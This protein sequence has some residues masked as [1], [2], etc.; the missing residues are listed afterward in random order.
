MIT[1]MP[2]RTAVPESTV[3]TLAVS[4]SASPAPVPA[5]RSDRM[6]AVAVM[7]RAF[8]AKDPA[9]DGLFIVAVK[10]T[11]IFCRPV[12]RAKTPRPENVEFYP[13][14]DAAE[15]QGYR[16]CKLCRPADATAATAPPP[17]VARLVR[18]AG[19]RFPDRVTSADLTAEGVDPATAR[20]QFRRHFGM[21]FAAYQ[22]SRRLAAAIGEAKTGRG[23]L[24]TAQVAAGFES[25]SG[26]RSAARKA[27]GSALAADLGSA[28]V[29]TSARI[30]TPIGPMLAIVGPIG[31]GSGAAGSFDFD[32]GPGCQ[33]RGRGPP[34][35]WPRVP[36]GPPQQPRVA[37]P[38]HDWVAR[39]T[40]RGPP[41]KA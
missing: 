2:T 17:T 9:F 21:T 1:D 29:L 35:M 19:E 24:M 3:A 25:A 10:T 37:T 34:L 5:N 39:R 18:L 26:F 41:V 7:R 28:V 20:R 4:S 33:P 12:C 14:P 8:A 36:R 13:S 23:N 32:V 15:R 40:P 38:A 31:D 16:P 11:G 27:T 6:P 22:R 30:P